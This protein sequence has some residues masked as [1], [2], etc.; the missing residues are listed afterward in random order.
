MSI[1]GIH[2]AYVGTSAERIDFRG[3]SIVYWLELIPEINFSLE[4]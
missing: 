1:R 2:Q 3:V 4:C